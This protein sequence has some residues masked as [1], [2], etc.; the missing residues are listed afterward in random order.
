MHSQV[1]ERLLSG[2]AYSDK[3]GGSTTLL[4]CASAVIGDHKSSVLDEQHVIPLDDLCPYHQHVHVVANQPT[5]S[6]FVD[7]QTSVEGSAAGDDYRTSP[8]LELHDRPLV[9]GGRLPTYDRLPAYVSGGFPSG[10]TATGSGRTSGNSRRSFV[11]FKPPPPATAHITRA[12]LPVGAR[13][14]PTGNCVSLDLIRTLRSSSTTSQAVETVDISS[15][16]EDV[17][18]S[19][20]SV[21]VGCVSL[22]QPSSE[23]CS[24]V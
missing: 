2:H 6:P 8:E 1:D 10:T 4:R 7:L 16:H 12:E 9:D 13:T 11:T 14:A 5:S 20:D 15:S 24:A 22:A 3:F 21:T 18:D 19:P 23:A 17:C